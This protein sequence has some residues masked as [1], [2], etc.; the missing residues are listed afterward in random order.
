MNN[1]HYAQ[2]FKLLSNT[3]ET[4]IEMSTTKQPNPEKPEGESEQI[5]LKVVS[6]NVK[7]N[8]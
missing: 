8:T 1:D 6:I 4:T 2:E 3:A 5:M 7:D